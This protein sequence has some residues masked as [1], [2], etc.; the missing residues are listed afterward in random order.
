M[1]E[2][3]ILVLEDERAIAEMIEII[4]RKEGINNITLCNTI[5]EAKDEMNTK[6]FDFYLL[7]IMLPDGSGLDMANSIR[8]KSDAPIFYLTAKSS[9]ADK[10]RG[11]MNGADDYITKPFNPLELVARVK[12]QLVRYMKKK[13]VPENHIF[14][15]RRFTFDSD[16]AEIEV[17][18][19]KEIISGRLFHLLKYLCDNAGQVLSKEQIYE[20]VW[21]DCLFD[22]NTVMVHIR[23]LREKIE[24]NPG[25]PTCIITVRGIGYKLVGDISS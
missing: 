16:A 3:S 4:L 23:K 25:K 5:E 1:Q 11:F 13:S 19:V 7:D 21:G 20:R 22:D 2:A 15:C 9:D 24:K 12:V 14:T 18:G 10:L 6:T 17:D 8:E